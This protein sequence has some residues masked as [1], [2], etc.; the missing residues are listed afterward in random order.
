MNIVWLE[1]DSMRV[2]LPRP[3][4][5]HQW[6][7]YA[8]TAPHAVL[9]RV[10]EADILLINKVKV[11]DAV[12]AAA[13]RLK[14]IQLMATGMDNVDAKAAAARGITVR[15]VLNYGPESVAEHV[16]A[17]ILQLTRRVPE[18][19]SLVNAGDWSKSKFFCMHNF[20]MRSL[21]VMTLGILGNGAI[22]DHVAQFAK[23]FGM[24]VVKV[25]RRGVEQVRP[26]Y[27]GFDEALATCDVISLHCPLNE[28]TRGLMGEAEF[29]RMKPGAILVNTARGALVQFE[30]LKR[31]LDSGHLGGAALDVL[32]VEPPPANHPMLT[33]QHPRCIVTP[34]IAW[35]TEQAQRNLASIAMR[36]VSEFM[37]GL[38]R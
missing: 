22:G 3:E 36:Q 4:Q 7:E 29:A 32:E 25:E 1:K 37:A 31:A 2:P 16:L 23:A 26:G 34:H 6:V 10:R 27:V 9:D 12:M 30:P 13:P 20:P 21:K 8:D 11:D 18:W 35:A 33:W 17:C 24:T 14:M 5:P 38:P 15:N 28:Q 19:Q